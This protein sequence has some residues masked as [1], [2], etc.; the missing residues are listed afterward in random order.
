MTN[1]TIIKKLVTYGLSETEAKLYCS[2]LALE[3]ASVDKLARYA[4]LNRTSTYPVL[5]RLKELGLVSQGK[6]KKHTVYKAVSPEKLIDLLEE[7]KET[8]VSIMPDLKSLL[9]I[10]R[11]RPDV[12]FFEGTEGLKTVLNDILKEAKEI[13]ILGDGEN[14]INLIP[15]W[16]EAY[17][18]K[19]AD[20]NIKV[21]LIIRATPYDLKSIKKLLASNNK[22]NQLLNVRVL[23]EIYKIHQGGFDIYNNKVVLYSFEKQNHAVVIES[24]VINQV[25]RTVFNLLWETAEKYNHLLK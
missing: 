10:S 3:E 14:F 9:A 13:Y 2:C 18:N 1:E 20:K 21:K 5:E 17:V 4:D 24:N 19:R 22:V 8:L 16:M 12:S 11:G 23:P 7:K 15:G 25:M 6:K